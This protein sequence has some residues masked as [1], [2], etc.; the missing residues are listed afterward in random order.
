[1]INP[2]PGRYSKNE[3][4]KKSNRAKQIRPGLENFQKKTDSAE[5]EDI[6]SKKEIPSS[7]R[8][9]P[10]EIEIE[11]DVNEAQK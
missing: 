10:C 2:L 3:R 7:R 6:Q 5:N 9:V 4:W 8:P 1:M 11:A